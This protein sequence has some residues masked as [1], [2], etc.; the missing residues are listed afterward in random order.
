MNK[1]ERKKI[2][3]AISGFLL[4][5]CLISS[6]FLGTRY[7]FKN[8]VDALITSKNVLMAKTVALVH[9]GMGTEKALNVLA[10]FQKLQGVSN[11]FITAKGKTDEFGIASGTGIQFH[12]TGTILKNSKIKDTVQNRIREWTLWLADI[13]QKNSDAPDSVYQTVLE[14]E[15]SDSVWMSAFPYKSG[16][17]SGFAGIIRIRDESHFRDIWANIAFA[18][19]MSLLLGIML[20]IRQSRVIGAISFTVLANVFLYLFTGTANEIQYHE[21]SI[22]ETI[23]KIA[24]SSLGSLPYGIF[25]VQSLSGTGNLAVFMYIASSITGFLIIFFC[26]KKTADLIEEIWNKPFVFISITPTIIGVILLT[27]TPFIM[28]VTLSFFNNNYEFIGITNFREILFP[29][30]TGDTN[31]YFTFGVTLMWTFLNVFLHVVIGLALALLLSDSTIRGKGIYRVLLIVPWAVPNYITALIWKWMFNTQYGPI[32]AILSI[33]GI[34]K[35]DWLGTSFWTNFSANLITN[36]WLG[37]PFMMVVSLG[38]LQSIPRELYEAADIDGAGRWYKFRHVTLPLLKPA[39]F[40]AII[41]GT[42]WTFNMFNVVY[43]V[44][45]G[46]PD[47][48]TNILITEAYRAFRVLKRFGFAAAYSLIIF[49]ILFVYTTV[50]NKIT[51]ATEGAFD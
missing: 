48:Q 19:F 37:F 49:V 2:C 14:I 15:G 18:G 26:L 27:F 21:I 36:T 46:A 38:A 17:G 3:Y 16:S 31:F 41:L 45:G 32:N 23:V 10:K 44:S 39:L 22:I 47:N 1:D 42:I 5:F 20:F 29:Q 28:G 40:P 25:D 4:S 33:F 11:I 6:I 34:E 24:R 8:N 51:K 9:A 50:T 12:G 7:Y 30:T 35:I 13:L 43:L